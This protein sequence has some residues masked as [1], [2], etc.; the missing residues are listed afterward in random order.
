MAPDEADA[1][2]LDRLEPIRQAHLSRVVVCDPA[3]R[4]TDPDP[5]RISLHDLPLHIPW[6]S[7]SFQGR[8]QKS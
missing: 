5:E 8:A 4:H 6:E 2:V 1:L 3:C 7:S